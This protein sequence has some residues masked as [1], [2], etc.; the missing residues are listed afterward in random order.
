LRMVNISWWLNIEPLVCFLF[1]AW[2]A[3]Y[4]IAYV[5]NIC[6]RLV[7]EEVIV[8][9]KPCLVADVGTYNQCHGGR[10]KARRQR[11][12]PISFQ[13]VHHPNCLLYPRGRF[14]IGFMPVRMRSSTARRVDD[15][16]PMVF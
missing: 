9:T 1:I 10:K 2:R 15:G 14:A 12:A 7:K 5:I 3:V 4:R 13:C 8:N 6:Q 11:P 16:R